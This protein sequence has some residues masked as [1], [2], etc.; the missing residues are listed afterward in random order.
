MQHGKT[1]LLVSL[2]GALAPDTVAHEIGHI[3]GADHGTYLLNGA[4]KIT[5][6]KKL[7]YF[8]T[9]NFLKIKYKN[10]QQKKSF[11]AEI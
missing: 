7:G 1:G 2:V 11:K 5:N 8:F 6:K 10:D 3:I 4:A 9:N